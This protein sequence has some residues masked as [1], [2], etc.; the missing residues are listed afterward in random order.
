MNVEQLVVM[1]SAREP[2]YSDKTCCNVTLSTTDRKNG[3]VTSGKQ[4]YI[5]IGEF[6]VSDNLFSYEKEKLAVK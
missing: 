4:L 5:L 6:S 1:K 3:I 2:K